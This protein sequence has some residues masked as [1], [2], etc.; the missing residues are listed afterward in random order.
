MT[1][2]VWT[3]KV[4]NRLN[5]DWS[6]R[7]D[8]KAF[9]TFELAC[10]LGNDFL[11]VGC[12]TGRF[13]DF[14]EKTH[15]EKTSKYIGLDSSEAMLKIAKDKYPNEK[16]FVCDITKP[17]CW[18]ADIVLCCEVL[19]H[20]N[21]EQQYDTLKN[22]MKAARKHIVLTTQCSDTPR[23]H[24]VKLE[25][26]SFTNTVQNYQFFLEVLKS[27]VGNVVIYSISS[28]L[29]DDISY[30]ISHIDLGRGIHN[31]QNYSAKVKA[32]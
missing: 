31:G 24:T 19:I 25:D 16:F 21:L 11:D 32:V 2:N 5:E 7:K 17:Y 3:K 23:I 18:K 14:I 1:T 4:A 6:S 30:I 26:Q 29:I 20:Q 27:V 13:K 9:D 15:P 28:H 22:I 12:G 8:S 10:S